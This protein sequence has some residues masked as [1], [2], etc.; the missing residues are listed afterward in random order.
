MSQFRIKVDLSDVMGQARGIIDASVLPRLNQAVSAVAQQATI[1]WKEAVARAKLWSG[2]KQQYGESI[3][4]KMTGA[5]SAEVSSDYKWAQEIDSGRPARD[6]KKMLDT[7]L[8]VRLSKKG[9]RYLIIPFRHGV[10]GANALAPSMPDD[11]YELARQLDP[12]RVTGTGRRLSGTGAFDIKSRKPLTVP[13]RKYAWGGSLPAGATPKMQS[14]HAGMY[15]FDT[16]SGNA[17]SSTYLTFRVMVEGS[18]G[19]IVPAKPGLNLVKGV[20]D[21]LQPLAEKAFSE[22]VKRDLGG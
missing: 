22:A 3:T 4:W 13:Q 1:D 19:W 6:L 15:R 18:P 14:R 7:S 8:K 16:S 2:E 5:F 10:P 12:S 20:T 21:R 17:K 11:V 9:A